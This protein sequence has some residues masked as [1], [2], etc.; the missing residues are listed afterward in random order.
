MAEVLVSKCLLAI[1]NNY[2]PI[3]HLLIGYLPIS[4]LPFGY[5]PVQMLVTA[6]F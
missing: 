6:C 1:I 5:L 3:G 2:L 4:Y